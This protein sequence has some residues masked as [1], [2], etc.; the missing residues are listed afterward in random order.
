MKENYTYAAICSSENNCMTLYFPDF[1]EATYTDMASDWMTAAQ[2][3]LAL[4]IIAAQ[5]K[6]EALPAETWY[7]HAEDPQQA[8]VYINVWLPY[9]RSKIKE[10]YIKKTLTIP[11]WIDVLAK[12]NHINFSE[13][14]VEALKEKLGIED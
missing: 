14:L 10:V 12:Q 2:D 1:D 11:S 4:R 8:I 6:G 9:H 13:T 5:D 3:W 7:T